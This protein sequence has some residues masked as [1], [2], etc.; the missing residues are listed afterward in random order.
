MKGAIGPVKT[1]GVLLAPLRSSVPVALMVA[2]LRAV[3][4]VMQAQMVVTAEGMVMVRMAE[5]YLETGNPGIG[6]LV[7]QQKWHGDLQQITEVVI[8]TGFVL[9]QPTTWI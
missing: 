3:Q 8:H 4:L 6:S 2:I 5:A 9:S 1:L 7:P